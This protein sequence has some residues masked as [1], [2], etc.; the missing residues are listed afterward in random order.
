LAKFKD[1]ARNLNLRNDHLS[2]KYSNKMNSS[3]ISSSH[4]RKKLLTYLAI[5]LLFLSI[6]LIV[7]ILLPT[8]S[9]LKAAEDNNIYHAAETRGMAINEWTRR[10]KELAWQVTSRTRI[11]QELEKLNRGEISIDQL[12][13]FTRPKL[14]DAMDLS[15]E[16][17]GIVR[18]DIA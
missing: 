5:G 17:L 2:I 8:Y 16:I 10:A 6:S 18:L 7:S 11:R 1:H 4:L 12:N 14:V 9:R 13:A 15:K 3:L